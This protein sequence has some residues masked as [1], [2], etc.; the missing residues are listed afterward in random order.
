MS[1]G[2]DRVALGEMPPRE[3]DQQTRKSVTSLSQKRVSGFRFING[4]VTVPT[5]VYAR[6]LTRKQVERRCMKF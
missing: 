2:I 5:V 4:S 3:A 6:R 1:K